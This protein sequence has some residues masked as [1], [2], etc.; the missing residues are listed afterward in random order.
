[1]IVLSED[2]LTKSLYNELSC[3]IHRKGWGD[4]WHS[5]CDSSSTLMTL[6]LLYDCNIQ[7]STLDLH[8]T[9]HYITIPMCPCET[10]WLE[11]TTQ[12]ITN[13]QSIVVRKILWH[14][15]DG[16]GG[17]L[18]P[19]LVTRDGVQGEIF[20]GQ[21]LT[22][23]AFRCIGMASLSNLFDNICMVGLHAS[24]T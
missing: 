2:W 18:M 9:W 14:A 21:A 19:S 15:F 4:P 7:L 6:H 22:S 17:H 20:L 10:K 3:S 16:E 11:K 5:P 8:L 12:D 24:K 1:M 23:I 13:T